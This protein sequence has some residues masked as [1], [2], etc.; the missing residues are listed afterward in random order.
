VSKL[1]NDTSKVSLSI[2]SK[3]ISSFIFYYQA[4]YVAIIL[5][6]GSLG[7]LKIVIYIIVI[8]LI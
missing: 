5:F 4:E 8:N 1:K 7:I 6:I 3:N 2:L